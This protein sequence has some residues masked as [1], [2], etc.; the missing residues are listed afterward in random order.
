MYHFI[1]IGSGVGGS[2]LFKELNRK[3]PNK[4]ILLLEMGN[5]KMK[6]NIIKGEIHVLYITSLGGSGLGAVGNA[7]R[8]DL[9]KVGIKDSEIY[10]EIERELNVREVPDNYINER[11]RSLFDYGFK[12]TPKFIDFER[13]TSCGMC[14]RKPCPFKWTPLRFLSTS[15]PYSKILSN[16]YVSSLSKEGDIFTVE[17][18][19][20]LTGK[21]MV[22]Q[23]ERVIVCGGGINSPRILSSILDNEHLGRNLF[24]DTFITVGGILKNCNLD[25]SIPMALYRIYSGFLL[26][27]HYSVLLYRSIKRE[28]KDVSTKDIYGIMVKI[29]DEGKGYV[30]GDKVY[31]GVT[32]RDEKLLSRGIKKAS[33]ILQ[34]MGV[35]G[36]YRT[37]LRG[38]HPGGTCAMGKVVDKNFETEVEGLYVCDASV[39]PESPGLPPILGIVAMGKK[40]GSIL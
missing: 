8:I 24:V 40:L 5:N 36:I 17:G 37:I 30:K 28:K 3:Y 1:I 18:C 38:S 34:A 13:C 29:G 26:S 15:N 31:K 23:G 20:L 12:R 19:H 7:I 35:E 32:K 22:F 9:R 11:S 16:F 39:F 2:T 27:P 21:R 33:D 25:R 6:Y 14:A 4:R 10:E